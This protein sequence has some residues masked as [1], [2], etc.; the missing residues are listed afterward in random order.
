MRKGFTLVETIVAL[1][2]LQ[3][4]MLA[5]AS[6][7]GV[8]ARDLSDAQMRRRAMTIARNGAESLRVSACAGGTSGDRTAGR[9]LRESWRTESFGRARAVT[10]SVSASLSRGRTVAVVAR[11][12][13]LCA[14]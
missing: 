12:W 8:A 9:G 11:L 5:L 13:I 3:I 6:T 14:D 7:A 10:D 1:V 4:G 2:L